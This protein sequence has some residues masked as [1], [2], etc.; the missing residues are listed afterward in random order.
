[1]EGR[2]AVDN[3]G[4]ELKSNKAAQKTSMRR[5]ARKPRLPSTGGKPSLC[6]VKPDRVNL[7]EAQPS[8]SQ[9]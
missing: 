9:D 1:M 7:F 6:K 5:T 8:A 4:P 3:V 2:A